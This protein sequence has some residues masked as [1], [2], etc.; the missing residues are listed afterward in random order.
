MSEEERNDLIRMIQI[1]DN[2]PTHEGMIEYMKKVIDLNPE[3]TQTE[4][5]LLSVCY[6]NFID[7]CRGN[8]RSIDAH[9]KDDPTLNSREKCVEYLQKRQ[10]EIY[11]ELKNYCNDLLQLVESKLLPVAKDNKSKAFYY[12]LMA[13][14]YRYLCEALS[15]KEKE[16][17]SQKAD[18]YYKEAI[19]LV[20][21][22]VPSYSPSSLGIYLNYCV[23]LCETAQKKSEAIEL[24]KQTYDKNFPL[25]ENNSETSSD[26]ARMILKLLEENIN[27]WVST[28]EAKNE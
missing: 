8:L 14:Y 16:E 3:L 11:E 7:V 27:L 20:K 5:N 19:E 6:K 2:T 13:D 24:A 1:L 12:K 10:Q 9:L 28:A 4:Q 26:E 17:A 21:D 22:D 15:D 23:Y 18:H 25:I